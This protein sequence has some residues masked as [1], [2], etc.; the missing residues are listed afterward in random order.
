MRPSRT[1]WIIAFAVVGSALTHAAAASMHAQPSPLRE[2]LLR[3]AEGAPPSQWRTIPGVRWRTFLPPDAPQ[4]NG[5]LEWQGQLR[6]QGFGEVMV[7]KG[8]GADNRAVKANEGDA[9]LLVQGDAREGVRTIELVKYHASADYAG[10]L[11]RQLRGRDKVVLVADGCATDRYGEGNDPGRTAIYRID[12]EATAM[13]VY[14]EASRDEAGT[15]YS[16]GETMLS[17]TRKRPSDHHMAR[18]GCSIH[19][20]EDRAR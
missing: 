17:F 6:L 8:V 7:P 16:P 1:P 5:R 3:L 4:G 20:A 11:R 13:P 15:R 19:K 9:R 2:L 18:M 12:L 10:V 14:A